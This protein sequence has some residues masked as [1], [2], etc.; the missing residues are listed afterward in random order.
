MLVLVEGKGDVRAVGRLV[1]RLLAEKAAFD[2]LFL[3]DEAFK[4]GSI[5]RLTGNNR[6]EWI[7]LLQAAYRV[8]SQTAAMLVLLDGDAD[9]VEGQTFCAMTVARSLAERA[10]YV[11]AGTLFSLACVFAVKEF[12]A[13]LIAGIESLAGRNLPDRISGIRAGVVAPLNPEQIRDCKGWLRENMQRPYNPT[14]HQEPMARLLDLQRLRDRNVRS[15][16][17]LE[18]AVDEL[19]MAVRSGKHI[20]SPAAR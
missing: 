1:G 19:I 8:R 15:F 7:R 4:I 16:M 10:A 11:G 13:W 3:D 5:E 18:H 20:S 14:I 12:E 2:C 9:A 6:H 17:R